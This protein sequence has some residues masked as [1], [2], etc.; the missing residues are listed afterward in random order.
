MIGKTINVN[1]D[2]QIAIEDRN[3]Q[4]LKREV[5]VKGKNIGDEKWV[6]EGYFYEMEILCDQLLDLMVMNAPETETI[7]ELKDAV[8]EAKAEILDAISQL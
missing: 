8:M 1:D 3:F 6:S 4:I 7:E 5:K 2:F